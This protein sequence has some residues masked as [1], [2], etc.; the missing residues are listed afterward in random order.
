MIKNYFKIAFRNLKKY[1]GYSFINITGLAVGLACVLLISLFVLDELSYDK[2]HKDADNLYRIGFVNK[3]KEVNYFTPT[4]FA[5]ALK[6]EIPGIIATQRLASYAG[7]LIT[8]GIDAFYESGYIGADADFFSFFSFKLLAGNPDKVLS[9]KESIVIVKSLADK[10][11]GLEDPIGK[12][13]KL[14]GKEKIITGI[15]ADPP[16]NSH[17]TFKIVIPHKFSEDD[18]QEWSWSMYQTY[19][20]LLKDYSLE[21]IGDKIKEIFIKNR[22]SDKDENTYIL[23][24]ITSIHLY[25]G[26]K[27]DF[28][29]AGSDIRYV[30]IFTCIALLILFIACINYTNLATARSMRRAKEVGI[31]KVSGASRRQIMYQFIGETLM[32]TLVAV[33]LAGVL[34][35]IALPL[36]NQITDKTL[37]FRLL[38][39]E[40]FSLLL[41]TT[42]VTSIIAG[43]YPAFFLSAFSPQ[44]ILKGIL[45]GKKTNVSF[46]EILVV[47][48]F[49]ITLI[50]VIG[51]IVIHKQLQYIQIKRLGFDKENVLL[52]NKR[53]ALKGDKLSSFMNEVKQLNEVENLAVG[54]MPGMTM[55]G[56]VTPEGLGENE[57]LVTA[58]I[59]YVDFNFM[60]TLGIEV[61]QGRA[62]SEMLPGDSINSIIINESAVKEFGW[63][64]NPIG[65][66]V[67]K[68]EYNFYT[69]ESIEKEFQVIG[70]VKDFHFLSLKQHIT[71]LI[72]QI[73]PYNKLYSQ[74]GIRYKTENLSEFLETL[75]DIWKRHV[76]DKPFEYTFLDETFDKYYRSEQKLA[77]IFWAFTGLTI[78][79]AILGLFGL[80]SYS[81]EQRRKEIGIRK[82]LGASVF[83]VIK[84]FIRDYNR[85]VFIAMLI[86]IPVAWYIAHQWLNDFAY[87]INVGID[88]LI[89][90]S[91]AVLIISWITVSYQ[92]LKAAR[93]NP[94]KTLRDN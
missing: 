81:A 22:K 35:E 61:K 27:G 42:I 19:A 70:V 13:L 64:D 51:A 15:A 34:V 78:L 43:S 52:T 2:F 83:S 36:F 30:Y 38:S 53:I 37:D 82:V 7:P 93:V 71:P 24:P 44:N 32:L 18:E 73:K 87:K 69:R 60:T 49:A 80:A 89:I 46:R 86:S 91:I 12:T 67:S 72:L 74:L 85:L 23:E 25:S 45:H 56:P 1:K 90:A 57:G 11:F 26:P 28:F 9:D 58:S 4:P 75:E 39:I 33:L 48:Q 20:K 76:P 40:T 68:R 94:V 92:S 16:T 10:Y 47:F 88:I 31:R 3:K 50:L 79:I 41:A 17:I 55:T 21:G 6:N 84:L 54:P 63:S 65:K 59:S 29:K 66:R 77:K 5:P 8:N 62:F 14:N